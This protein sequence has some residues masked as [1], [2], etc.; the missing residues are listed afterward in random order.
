M[1]QSKFWVDD[2]TQLFRS[3]NI[4]P[5]R[6]NELTNNLNIIMRLGIVSSIIIATVKPILGIV[7]LVLFASI[8]SVSYYSSQTTENFTELEEFKKEFVPDNPFP[9]LNPNFPST[10]TRF[11]NDAVPWDENECGPN[12][13]LSG[14]ANPKTLIPP[15]VATP[16]HDPK[17]R[18]NIPHSMTNSGN[19]YDVYRSGACEEP[20][21]KFI[22]EDNIRD[23]REND[24]NL[25]DNIR[26]V[27]ENFDPEKNLD[28]LYWRRN[29][30]SDITRE[31]NYN[32]YTE[33][34][35]SSQYKENTDSPYK[36][37]VLTQT[38]QPGVFQKTNIGE[39]IQSNI[40]ITF[41]PEFV[42]TGIQDM[43][44]KIKYTQY[45][46]ADVDPN[47]T[48][49]DIQTTRDNTY[50]PRFTG[51]GT[52]YRSYIDNMGRPQFFYDD[53]NSV[54]MP[55]ITSRSKVDVFPWADTNPENYRQLANNSFTDATI[56]FRTEMQE[57]LM[58]K[59]NAELWQRRQFPI[60][61][62]NNLTYLRR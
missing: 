28:W 56:Q 50:D 21:T 41:T 13:S 4:L 31:E 32:S 3:F 46:P 33:A 37:N 59:R 26:D 15:I 9:E 38:L 24:V 58:R 34:S 20:C 7:V 19:S 54:T 55:L 5:S 27:R 49:P 45:N 23:V 40:G 16:S 10:Q 44:G 51:Y 42:P 11:C 47:P 57:S 25:E 61:T 52:S 17:W 53:I 18:N 29:N 8:T 48:I 22:A 60:S 2:V 35:Q 1:S 39:P 62:M 6:D 36:D 30:H 14:L 12:A 43:N